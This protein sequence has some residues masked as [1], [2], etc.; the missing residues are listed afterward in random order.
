MF[1]KTA[2]KSYYYTQFK[3]YKDDIK[4]TWTLIRDVIGSQSKTRENLENLFR[5]NKNILNNIADGFN[6]FL[7]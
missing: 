3:I 2:K 7:R 5:Q 1:K 4:Q 6:D